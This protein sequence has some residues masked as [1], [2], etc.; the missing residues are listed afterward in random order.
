MK[1][2]PYFDSKIDKKKERFRIILDNRKLEIELFWKRSLFFWGFI[3]STFVGFA[4]LYKENIGLSL[5]ISCFGMVCS[6]AWTMANRGSKYW[7]ENWE[8]KVIRFENEIIGPVFIVQEPIQDKGFWLKGRKY[9]VSKLAIALSDYVL[10]LWFLITIWQIIN[11]FSLNSILLRVV[12]K[13]IFSIFSLAYIAIMFWKCKT[14]SA[15]IKPTGC[16]YPKH[17]F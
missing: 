1:N 3:A 11:L 13:M 8:A 2:R 15:I 5:I 14:S 12:C 6:Y 17:N 4:T 7:Q 9:S 16:S 10:I